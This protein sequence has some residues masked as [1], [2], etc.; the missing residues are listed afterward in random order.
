[1]AAAIPYAIHGG[2][3][4]FSHFKNKKANAAQQAATA[5]T[6]QVGQQLSGLVGPLTQQGQQLTGQGART[7]GT[8]GDYYQNILGSRQ[9]ATQ[10]MAPETTTAL[11]Y[12]RGAENKT[13]RT[14]QGGARDQALAELDR[15]KVGQIAGFLPAA[16]RMA[17]EG[18]TNVGGTQ[19]QAGSA[20]SG[21]AVNA[22]TGAA[23]A[24]NAAFGQYQDQRKNSADT[25]SAWGKILSGAL[26]AWQASRGGGAS[27]GA[28]N[29]WYRQGTN[30]A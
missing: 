27:S 13:K 26:G 17:A 25:A 7:L 28:Q 9:V 5:G 29:P 14:M 15:Q 10:S 16:R 6:Q 4:L 1:M 2:A 20:A 24:N 12:Y 8:A 3:A 21:Q 18:A 22:G 19:L 23:Y 30:S 11:E